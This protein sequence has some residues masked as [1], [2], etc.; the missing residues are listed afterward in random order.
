MFHVR[1]GTADVHILA[2]NCRLGQWH[3]LNTDLSSLQHTLEFSWFQ[4]WQLSSSA[5]LLKQS[6]RFKNRDWKCMCKIDKW[7]QHLNIFHLHS[8]VVESIRDARSLCFPWSLD[9]SRWKPA[10][11]LINDT[12]RNLSVWQP[13]SPPLHFST[14][15]TPFISLLYYFQL[16]LISLLAML[17]TTFF[18]LYQNCTISLRHILS[19]HYLI[20]SSLTFQ[21]CLWHYTTSFHFP[22]FHPHLIALLSITS[23]LSFQ[24]STNALF[25]LAKSVRNRTTLIIRKRTLS[26]KYARLWTANGSCQCWTADRMPKFSLQVWDEVLAAFT[27]VTNSP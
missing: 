14:A 26:S 9:A 19:L 8:T 4:V 21:L 23:F 12:Q 25:P 11:T 20:M 10:T 24:V 16:T 6:S 18:S 3:V 27:N 13:V 2:S 15:A 1:V 22:S 7:R 5:P 17:L